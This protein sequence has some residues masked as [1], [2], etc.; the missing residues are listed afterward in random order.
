MPR[1]IYWL[2]AIAIVYAVWTYRPTPSTNLA[3][4]PNSQPVVNGVQTVNGYHIRDLEPY[5]GEFRI[6][7]S[8]TYS[9]GRE[10]EFSP[11][12]LA[13]GW[14]DMARPEVYS[15]IDIQQ[16]NRWYYW[17]VDAFPISRRDIE[18]HS[19]NM[20]IIPA[21]ASIAAAL[22]DLEAGDLVYLQGALVEIQA[23]DGWRWRSSLSREDTGGGACEVMRVDQVIKRA[24]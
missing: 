13:V 8:Q 17:H 22:K 4:M 3:D 21:N 10:A 24:G 7:G 1:F 5:E 19:A 2:L 12:D 23:P 11:L 9:S 14:G 18:T 6:L 16:S 20:H 15:K